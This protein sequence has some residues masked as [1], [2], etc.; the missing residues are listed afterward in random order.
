MM[1]N[2]HTRQFICLAAGGTGGHVYPA[3]AVAEQLQAQG[4]QTLLFTDRRGR[5]MVSG[6]PFACIAAASPFQRN[7]W[8]R[9]R[10][11]ILLAGGAAS[12]LLRLLARRPAVMIGF[13]GYPSFAPLFVAN[14][15]RIPT[16]V[17]EQNAYLGR[18]NRLLAQR[19]G[20]LA[21]SWDQTGNLPETVH[22]FVSGMPVR[23]AFFTL[24]SYPT[25][26][27]GPLKLAVIGGSQGAGIFADL[28]PQALAAL[29]DTIRARLVLTQ[30]CRREQIDALE[31]T[32]SAMGLEARLAPF[33]DDVPTIL[34]ESHLVIGRAGASSVAELAAAGR[35]AIL[36]PL[37]GAM[38]DH[39]SAN[40][41]QLAR[42]G[43]GIC[44]KETG[45]SAHHLADALTSLLGDAGTLTAMAKNAR[46]LGMPNAA[47]RIADAALAL[48][49]GH[50][51]QLGDA[52]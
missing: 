29:P 20:H 51:L 15:L 2:T 31:K 41:N 3:L 11:L 44:L 27:D 17:H 16:I 13:G 6:T 35:P 1:A 32:Y 49:G 47:G 12:A 39:Q 9:L 4:H 7:L 45:L 28:V 48:A 25:S 8:Q 33:F 10:S 21:L 23:K 22:C 43:G 19:A 36:I 52:G 5:H 34:A 38:D 30:Q 50:K 14:L 18:A 37:P 40:A 26:N 42:V 24:G 46:K